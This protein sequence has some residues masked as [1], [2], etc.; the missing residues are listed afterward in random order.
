MYCIR[1]KKV[2]KGKGNKGFRM[3]KSK[4]NSI[5]NICK[6]FKQR[7]QQRNDQYQS[8]LIVIPQK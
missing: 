5:E 8:K 1:N 4:L 2:V 3:A 6:V 7:I